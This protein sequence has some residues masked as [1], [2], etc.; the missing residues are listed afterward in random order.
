MDFKEAISLARAGNE[1]GFGY[2]YE[3]TYKSK[4]YLALQYMKNEEAAKD[5]VQDAY[6]KAFSNLD[7]LQNPYAFSGWL[8]TIIANTAKN[9][10]QKKNPM[11]FSE[12]AVSDENEKYEYEIEDENAENQ[13]EL[14]YTRKE[15]QELVR[16]MLDSLSEE[17]RICMLMFHIEGASIKEIADA[18]DCSDNT[19]KSRL[20]YGRKNLKIK[21]EELQKKGYKL[22]SIAP[23]PFFIY[24]LCSDQ[25]I[26]AMDGTL[27]AAGKAMAHEI[28]PHIPI[29]QTK[30]TKAGMSGT[31]GKG[32]AAAK[33]G[34][35]HTT[36]GKVTAIIVGICITGGAA[37]LGITHFLPKKAE[38]VKQEDTTRTEQ[39]TPPAEEEQVPVEKEVK[40]EDYPNLIEGNLTK[41]ELTFVL[42]YGPEEIPEQGFKDSDYLNY[43]AG[44]TCGNGSP[45]ENMGMDANYRNGYSLTEL[46]RLFSSFSEYQFNEDND[47]DTP[48]GIDVDGD[49]LWLAP[50]TL[51]WESKATITSASYTDTEMKVYF[52]FTKNSYEQGTT[53]VKKVATLTPATDGLYRITKIEIATEEE[54]DASDST[55]SQS[56]TSTDAIKQLYQGVLQSVQNQEEG[57]TF[58]N[59]GKVTGAYHYFLSDMNGDGIQE[60]IVGAE[61]EVDVFTGNMIRVFTCEKAGGDYQLKAITGEI[62]TIS[63]FFPSDGNGLYDYW[64]SRG[65]GAVRIYRITMQDGTITGGSTAQEE[66]QFTMGDSAD[67]AFENENKSVEW[68]DVSDLSGLNQIK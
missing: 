13:P 59:A 65:T 3:N 28:F 67:E 66:Q 38:P 42:A 55:S 58:P 52:D 24:L 50:P 8:G 33:T 4:Y 17:Q 5:V 43:L 19:V 41:E 31:T 45:V 68:K 64:L 23:L 53:E 21:A 1:R 62:Q 6:I 61:N 39:E 22:Y 44:L 56:K 12:V 46:N 20:N 25:K 47:S 57:Y 63:L 15:T 14:S 37:F 60:L 32:M 36:A 7:K 2:L 35:L 26:L 49:T 10:L 27:G 18:L 51:S 30:G 29:F 9:A 11:L 40:D 34:F 48:Y 54:P 16:E